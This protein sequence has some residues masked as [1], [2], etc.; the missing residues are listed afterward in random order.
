MGYILGI[1]D[2]HSQN[3]LVDVL[4]AEVVHI[5]FGIMFE[6]GKVLGT[7]ETGSAAYNFI[8]FECI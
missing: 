3:I 8:K 5:D 4:T 2:R 1:G 6:Q 7:P